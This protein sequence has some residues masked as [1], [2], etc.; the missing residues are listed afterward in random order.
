M[1][2]HQPDASKALFNIIAALTPLS[3]EER[4][5]TVD[6][7]MTFLGET[8]S[9]PRK[10]PDSSSGPNRPEQAEDEPQNVK[11]ATFI[12]TWMKQHHVSQDEL[13]QAFHFHDD[14]SFDLHNAPGKSK[15]EQTLNTY[16]LTGLGQY[17]VSGGERIFDDVQ[18]RAFCER[19]GC[20]DQANHASHLKNRG[21]EFTG[22]KMKGFTLTNPGIRRGASLV[23]ELASEAT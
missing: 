5:R 7:A 15:K 18:A 8:S 4:H 11:G 6:A 16:I 21:P 19:I 23:K 13:D 3:S 10:G 20:Y 17:L 9:A 22:D 12:G 14:G 1:T 2:D